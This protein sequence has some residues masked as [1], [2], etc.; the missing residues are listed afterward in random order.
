VQAES[1]A[2]KPE[3]IQKIPSEQRAKSSPMTQQPIAQ[4][5][6]NAEL[7]SQANR[8]VEEYTAQATKVRHPMGKGV[9]ADHEAFE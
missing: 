8:A 5:A 7:M 4:P 6:G 2:G 9:P 3:K 1:L